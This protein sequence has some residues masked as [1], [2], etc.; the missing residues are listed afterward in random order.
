MTSLWVAVT[1]ESYVATLCRQH[2]ADLHLPSGLDGGRLLWA[3]AGCESDFGH[4]A[5]PRHEPAY[6]RGG[7]YYNAVLSKKWGCAAHASYGPWQVMYEHMVTYAGPAGAPDPALFIRPAGDSSIAYQVMAQRA[8]GIA[9][10]ML[11]QEIFGRQQAATLAEAAKAWNH[12]NWR[13]QF[14]DSAYTER[15][16]HFY[17]TPFPEEASQA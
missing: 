14:D 2:A 6:C 8:I 5:L 11:N 16:A 13:D 3:L 12:G 10:A 4:Y 15:A 17:A 1:P 7:R 9:I